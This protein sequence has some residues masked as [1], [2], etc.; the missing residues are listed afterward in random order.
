VTAPAASEAHAIARK[1][2]AEKSVLRAIAHNLKR[3]EP[4]VSDDLDYIADLVAQAAAL[5]ERLVAAEP[6]EATREKYEREV[7]AKAVEVYGADVEAARN[8]LKRYRKGQWH[9]NGQIVREA[10][11]AAYEAIADAAR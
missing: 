7:V 8:V 11:D 9:I 3:N 10:L 5:I 4:P 2:L 1:L 6:D